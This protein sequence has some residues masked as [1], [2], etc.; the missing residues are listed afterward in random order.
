MNRKKERTES[1]F[2]TKLS[3]KLEKYNKFDCICLAMEMMF[4]EFE[5]KL[6]MSISANVILDTSL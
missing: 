2:V 6:I 1:N 5:I 4:W 3:F